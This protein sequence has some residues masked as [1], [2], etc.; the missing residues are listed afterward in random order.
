MSKRE[1]FKRGMYE[2]PT[3]NRDA[4]FWTINIWIKW[5]DEKGKW[6]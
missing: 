5:I 6:L 1:K 4:A 3:P 2:C